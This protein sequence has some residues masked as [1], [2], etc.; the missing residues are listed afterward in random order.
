MNEWYIFG[1]YYLDTCGNCMRAVSREKAPKEL[2]PNIPDVMIRENF[3]DFVRVNIEDEKNRGFSW[4][5]ECGIPEP[6]LTCGHCG[7]AWNI[8]NCHDTMV[9]HTTEVFPLNNLIGKTLG[10]VKEFYAKKTDAIYRMQRDILIRNDRFIDL[11]PKY[12]DAAEDWK[13]AW[14]KNEMGWVRDRDGITDSYIIQEGDEGHFNVW[15]YFH[16]S[17]YAERLE[18]ESKQE[19]FEIFKAAGFINFSMSKIPNEYCKCEKC[20]PWWNV[21]TIY[22]TLKI[23]WRKHVINIDWSGLI[24][25]FNRPGISKLFKEED[26]TMGATFIHADGREEAVEYLQNILEIL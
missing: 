23:G 21:N 11:S 9:K 12:P 8:G 25:P 24:P 2:L 14:V 4:T 3:W 16:K 17:C 18:N 1:C 22:G 7:L 5:Y 6:G 13:R 15:K 20:S 10:E 19:F 26:V